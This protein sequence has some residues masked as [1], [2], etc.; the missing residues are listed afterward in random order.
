MKKKERRFQTLEDIDETLALSSGA[1]KEKKRSVKRTAYFTEESIRDFL[2]EYGRLFAIPAVCVLLLL[3]ILILEAAGGTGKAAPQKEDAPVASLSEAVQETEAGTAGNAE[4]TAEAGFA[5]TEDSRINTTID[6]YFAAR[7]AADAD[8]L[9]RLFGRSGDSGK[10]AL[11]KKLRA[12]A[13]WIQSYDGITVYVLPGLNEKDKLCIVCYKINFRRTDTPAPGIM[14]C[15]LTEQ[16]DGSYVI[17]ENLLKDKVQYVNEQLS[18]PEVTALQEKVDEELRYAL[19]QDSTLS[20]IYTS[21]LN[22]EIYNETAPDVNAEQEVNLFLTPED[23]DLAGGIVIEQETEPAETAAV[24]IETDPS[25]SETGSF[26]TEPDTQAVQT[27]ETA[28]TPEDGSN[29]EGQEAA[30]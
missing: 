20:L 8:E 21:F 17:G 16:E 2:S 7:L 5:P 25:D 30:S 18:K 29:A 4:E 1:K 22:G 14:Y 3:L 13:S 12:Q 26:G 11:V 24:A 23:S 19:N 27:A 6:E 9:Y 10:D 15:Y 28:A